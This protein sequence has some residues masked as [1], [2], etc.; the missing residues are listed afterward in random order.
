MGIMINYVDLTISLISHN[1]KKD[2]ELLLPSLFLALSE[3][4]AEVLL[5]D[6]CSA[7]STVK[8]IKKN[9]PEIFLRKNKTKLGYGA[10]HNQNLATAKGQ[11]IVLMNA[12]MILTQ[13]AFFLLLKFK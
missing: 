7:D 5:I 11:Y 8:F 2:L 1:S 4:N 3:I 10:N 13:E 6:N 9:Y 12:D